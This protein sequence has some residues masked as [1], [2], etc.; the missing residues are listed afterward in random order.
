M[1]YKIT[2]LAWRKGKKWRL[3]WNKGGERVERYFTTE[4]EARTYMERAAHGGRERIARTRKESK[5]STIALTVDD[6]LNAYLA[7][8]GIREI[9]RKA[10]TYHA[11]HLRRLLGHRKASR[12]TEADAQGFHGGTARK[13]LAADNRKPPGK[14]PPSR[15]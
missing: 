3:A 5:R 10:D 9:T 15:L 8:D 2:F 14:N 4:Q 7:R 11:V 1:R 13:G 6:L 12:L